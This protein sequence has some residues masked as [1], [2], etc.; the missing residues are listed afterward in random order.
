MKKSAARDA[1]RNSSAT[2][3]KRKG[4]RRTKLSDAEIA[5]FYQRH[6]LSSDE[7]EVVE[8]SRR[9]F[10]SL[11]VALAQRNETDSTNLIF[12]IGQATAELGYLRSPT[13]IN[14]KKFTGNKRPRAKLYSE[15]EKILRKHGKAL[16][17]KR[18]MIAL[19]LAGVTVKD[20]RSTKIRW[21]DG[22][23]KKQKTSFKQFQNQL[24]NIRKTI[25]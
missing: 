5:E 4:K 1:S 7:A 18:V 25:D 8:K 23:G 2:K 10:E 11:K 15:A 20:K 14:A 19:E 3:A 9:M 12:D 21:I 22:K 6:G 24:S 17:S 16:S 13:A